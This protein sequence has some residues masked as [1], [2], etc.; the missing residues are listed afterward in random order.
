MKDLDKFPPSTPADHSCEYPLRPLWAMWVLPSWDSATCQ[1][2]ALIKSTPRSL[3]SPNQKCSPSPI[4]HPELW[5]VTSPSVV[6]YPQASYTTY[7]NHQRVYRLFL[8][9][10]SRISPFP[11]TV[12][13][14]IPS[15]NPITIMLPHFPAWL[16]Q[17]FNIWRV[18]SVVYISSIRVGISLICSPL[19]LYH[20]KISLTHNKQ[21]INIFEKKKGKKERR[22][23]KRGEGGKEGRKEGRWM[24]KGEKGRKEGRKEEEKKWDNSCWGF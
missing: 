17:R 1:S 23:E 18:C 5:L 2:M 21:P 13:R 6:S 7:P 10:P 15:G 22:G 9:N 8:Q 11:I 20:I 16:P 19:Y 24:R 14:T 12:T 4:S 3:C